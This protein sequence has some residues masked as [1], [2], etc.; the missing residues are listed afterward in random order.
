MTTGH[1]N[2]GAVRFE[3]DGEPAGVFV[4]HCSICRRSTGAHGIAVVLVPNGRFRWLQGEDRITR[5][6]RPGG[7]WDTAFCATCGSRLPGPNDPARMFV[8]AGLLPGQG[9]GL[10]VREHI[11]V[12]SRAEWDVIGDGGRQHA[13]A[14]GAGPPQGDAR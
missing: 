3:F 9:L 8:P 6:S 2:C 4:C 11:Y 10:Q 5:W 1:C 7:T 12:D 14:F 13:A